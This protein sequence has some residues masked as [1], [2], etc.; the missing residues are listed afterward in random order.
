[1]THLNNTRSCKCS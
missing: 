1:M